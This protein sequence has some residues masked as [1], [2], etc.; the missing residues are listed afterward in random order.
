M[1]TQL[2][3]GGS[4]HTPANPDATAMAV[5]DDTVVWVGYDDIGRRL[6]PEAE[7]VD[8]DGRFVGPGFV[9][10]HVHLT[11]T[12]LAQSG[13]DLSGAHHRGDLLALLTAYAAG[14]PED[15]VIWAHGW[16]ESAWVA[17]DAEQHLPPTAAVIVLDR[18]NNRLIVRRELVQPAVEAWR[19][20]SPRAINLEPG[21][22]Q[23]LAGMHSAPV[24]PIEYQ[25]ASAGDPWQGE[26]AS[27]LA[28]ALAYGELPWRPEGK[29]HPAEAQ[30]PVAPVAPCSPEG[31]ILAV[32][33]VHNDTVWGLLKL[34]TLRCGPLRLPTADAQVVQQFAD[35]LAQRTA[36][37]A[38][39]QHRD[40]EQ[41]RQDDGQLQMPGLRAVAG[42]AH[43]GGREH[44]ADEGQEDTRLRGQQLHR[45]QAVAVDDED[46]RDDVV[47]RAQ[48][49]EQ[50]HRHAPPWL[51][52]AA[53]PSAPAR[54]PP[55]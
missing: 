43:D 14:V 4:I 24:R 22:A 38:R 37:G 21:L 51:P 25:R 28:Q 3:L 17:V 16:D 52:C 30:T 48:A 11:A 42:D 10:S 53:P 33:L 15:D 12:G 41:Q 26:T 23:R 47:R 29:D 9:D 44:Q 18:E 45:T 2:L 8:L 31:G 39:H 34:S 27:W 55:P 32:P 54:H 6:H 19:L 40:E 5:T 36:V 20:P 49:P 35:R 50:P 13:L 46:Q 7:V 1:A